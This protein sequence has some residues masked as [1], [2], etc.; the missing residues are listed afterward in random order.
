MDRLTIYK[1]ILISFYKV[2]ELSEFFLTFLSQV[3]VI[4]HVPEWSYFPCAS[5]QY[6]TMTSRKVLNLI[7]LFSDLF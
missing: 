7:F 3:D 6:Y 1:D 4:G 5:E 2:A